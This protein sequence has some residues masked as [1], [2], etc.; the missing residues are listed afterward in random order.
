M[1]KTI[2]TASLGVGQKV[3]GQRTKFWGSTTG[4]GGVP[5]V[6]GQL[7]KYWADQKFKAKHFEGRTVKAAKKTMKNGNTDILEKKKCHSR[8]EKG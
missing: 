2:V 1:I 8:Q 6:W 5:K 4:L 3:W 7:K